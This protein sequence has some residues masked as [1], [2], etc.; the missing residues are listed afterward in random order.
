[1]ATGTHRRGGIVADFL[2]DLNKATQSILA[3]GALNLIAWIGTL[4]LGSSMI[5]WVMRGASVEMVNARASALSQLWPIVVPWLTALTAKSGITGS[6]K[7]EV[8]RSAAFLKSK[9][10]EADAT[11]QT[12]SMVARPPSTQSGEG[13]V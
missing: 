1:M 5:I 8:V 12:A 6:Q 13:T 10:V 4:L 9:Q 11:V 7:K 2:D 3:S